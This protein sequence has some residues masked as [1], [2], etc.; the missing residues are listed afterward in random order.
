MMWI[1]KLAWQRASSTFQS[2]V[3]FKVLGAGIPTAFS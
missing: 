3:S 2:M 1:L